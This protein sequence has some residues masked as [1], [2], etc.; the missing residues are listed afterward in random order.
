LTD[1]YPEEPNFFKK[2]LGISQRTFWQHIDRQGPWEE[3]LTRLMSY[4]A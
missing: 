3:D 1:L 4:S 2:K